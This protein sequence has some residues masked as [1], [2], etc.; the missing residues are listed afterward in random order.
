MF[1]ALSAPGFHVILTW[2]LKALCKLYQGLAMLG[3]RCQYR[4]ILTITEIHMKDRKATLV[5]CAECSLPPKANPNLHV[6]SQ[7]SPFPCPYVVEAGWLEKVGQR[8]FLV[9]NH[10][11]EKSHRRPNFIFLEY[12]G[13]QASGSSQYTPD[14]GKLE[15]GRSTLIN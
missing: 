12:L 11:N 3:T 10:T 2:T 6:G 14:K 5:L 4:I 1:R 13:F 7:S 8:M 9:T 15:S